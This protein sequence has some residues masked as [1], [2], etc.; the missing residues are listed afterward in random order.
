MIYFFCEFTERMLHQRLTQAIDRRLELSEDEE[1]YLYCIRSYAYLKKGMFSESISDSSKAIN[2]KPNDPDA[3]DNRAEAYKELHNYKAAISD[4]QAYVE[5]TD[6]EEGKIEAMGFIE[7][8]SAML[9]PDDS[10]E[11]PT[12]QSPEVEQQTENQ[13]ESETTQ[14]TPRQPASITETWINMGKAALANGFFAEA[15]THFDKVMEKEPSNVEAATCRLQ[16]IGAQTTLDDNLWNLYFQQINGVRDSIQENFPVSEKKKSLLLIAQAVHSLT[17][18]YMNLVKEH[19]D[20]RV[21]SLENQDD[22]L[23]VMEV[24][25]LIIRGINRFEYSLNFLEALEGPEADTLKLQLSKSKMNWITTLCEPTRFIS[26]A[27]RDGSGY[28]GLPDENRPEYIAMYDALMD[29]I[30]KVEPDYKPEK[31][32]DRLHNPTCVKEERERPAVLARMQAV[33]DKARQQRLADYEKQKYWETHPEEYIAH[34]KEEKRK[35]DEEK[36]RALAEEQKKAEERKARALAEQNRK[37]AQYEVRKQKLQNEIDERNLKLEQMKRETAKQVDLLRKER[38]SLGFLA[39]GKKNE[40]DQK[41]LTLEKQVFDFA[42]KTEV[43]RKEL[44]DLKP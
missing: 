33:V 22:L 40:I 16:A 21:Y 38:D 37:Q 19:R 28:A 10:T 1:M 34:L 17:D 41:I 31:L 30:V 25:N 9:G 6:D 4:A 8:M 12:L 44:K 20:E 3:Y 43:L 13:P 5:L 42:V 35:R 14:I 29:E 11:S 7:E 2:L 18:H 24:W 39:M 26:K 36:A 15:V 32:I 27:A 23:A